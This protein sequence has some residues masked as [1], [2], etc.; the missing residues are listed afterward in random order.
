MSGMG[1]ALEENAALDIKSMMPRTHNG[2]RWALSELASRAGAREIEP[3]EGEAPSIMA[4]GIVLCYGSPP[5]D[6]EAKDEEGNGRPEANDRPTIWIEPCSEAAP[7]AL[8]QL[9]VGSLT[10]FAPVELLPS[11][12]PADGAAACLAPDERFLAPL[13][14]ED[15]ERE[16]TLGA[17]DTVG[18]V[19]AAERTPLGAVLRVDIAAT[20]LMFL[21][22]WE[23]TV[24]DE[25]DQHGRFP[26]R[27][28]LA[29]RHGF[30]D[31][32]IV[33]EHAMVL[34]SWMKAVQPTWTP[35]VRR[36]D[37]R[38]SHDID[39]IRPFRGLRAA[40]RRVASDLLWR[41]KPGAAL[42]ALRDVAAQ[43]VAPAR[44]SSFRGIEELAAIAAEHGIP[45]AFLFQ[46][47]DPGPYD[48]DYDPRTEPVR[49]V[50]QRL[51]AAGH[52]VGLHPSYAAAE[53]PG[54]LASEIER[55]SGISPS[56]VEFSRQH[57]LRFR[58]PDTWC[59]LAAAGLV[60]D[61]SLGYADHEGFRAG[62]C[63]PYQPFDLERDEPID[64][65]EEPLIAMESTLLGYRGMST[66]EAS[67]RILELAQRCALVGGRMTLLWHNS[68]LH[69]GWETWGACY[70][71]TV[72]K[73]AE[74][75]KKS[76]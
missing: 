52:V 46:A 48:S 30:L 53:D 15:Y 11:G 41:R 12:A 62:T 60:R 17:I 26:A 37:V 43:L 42:K 74:L 23:E 76:A 68:K 38:L 40:A 22:R 34:R 4:D 10:T 69:G 73:L 33:D 67:D 47:G 50:I 28:A 16:S 9:S 7:S 25:A 49:S 1:G 36:F 56:P 18:T 65:I 45:A 31:R 14:A 71:A 58:A 21:S 59:D 19:P 29:F 35:N 61:M 13:L 54:R 63:H 5:S 32:P 6:D 24:V 66:V 8:I 27:A 2:I 75:R 72:P 44:T 55:L 3:L 70:R 57:Y 39:R 20:A 51:C 64:L